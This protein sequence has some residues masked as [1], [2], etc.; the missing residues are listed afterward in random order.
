MSNY[1][2]LYL[3]PKSLYETYQS[4]GDRAVRDGIASINIRQLN[5]IS[6]SVRAT[7]QANDITRGEKPPTSNATVKIAPASGTSSTLSKS[8]NFGQA[9]ASW[10]EGENF[11][12]VRE[13]GGDT[14]S[15]SSRDFS[16]STRLPP[17]QAQHVSPN[18]ISDHNISAPLSMLGDIPS[19][20]SHVPP[21]EDM[22]LDSTLPSSNA[23]THEF[24]A[25]VLN[26]C[27]LYGK[28]LMNF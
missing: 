13:E 5:N 22:S 6:D 26:V 15:V 20:S 27:L 18:D 12:Q 21:A 19:P 10:V 2:C 7:I 25:P 9:T 8:P 3:I 11:G 4:Q 23:H 1:E 17:P 14:N 24:A 16:T 28:E